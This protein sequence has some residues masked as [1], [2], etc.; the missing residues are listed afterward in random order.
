MKYPENSWSI[1][2][3]AQ[4]LFGKTKVS[5]DEIA[6]EWDKG[7]IVVMKKPNGQFHFIAGSMGDYSKIGQMQKCHHDQTLAA[8]GAWEVV[9]EISYETVDGVVNFKYAVEPALGKNFASKAAMAVFK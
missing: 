8:F 7:A 6:K 1:L 3:A 2:P 9:N 4:C 5:I